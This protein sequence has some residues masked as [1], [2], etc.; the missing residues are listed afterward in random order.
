MHL[1]GGLL[2]APLASAPTCLRRPLKGASSCQK[3]SETQATRNSKQSKTG[4]SL[5]LRQGFLAAARCP[6]LTKGG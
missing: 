6:A 1:V 3:A 2:D 4:D 5:P